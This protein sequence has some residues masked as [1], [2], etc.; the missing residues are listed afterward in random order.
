M[1]H[2]VVVCLCVVAFTGAGAVNALAKPAQQESFV[3][4]GYPAWWCR[5]TGVLEISVAVLIAF[6]D[7]R[8]AGLYLG[9][10]IMVAAAVTV[11]RHREFSHLVPIGVFSA[12]LAI[13]ALTI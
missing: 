13:V 11:I 8:I 2:I 3:R 7:T 1:L 5:L 6:P 12:V 9:A 10:I 4:W